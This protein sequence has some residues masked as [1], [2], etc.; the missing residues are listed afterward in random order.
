MKTTLEFYSKT[1]LTIYGLKKQYRWRAIA[2]NGKIIGASSE[3]F[4]NKKDCEDN[5][6]KLSS[7]LSHPQQVIHK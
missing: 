5:A 4:Y 2:A 6:F 3:G 1:K 7:V